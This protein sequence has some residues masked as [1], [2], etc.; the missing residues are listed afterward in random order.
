[1]RSFISNATSKV[2]L[3]QSLSMIYFPRS[4]SNKKEQI[5]S[6]NEYLTTSS[7]MK[8]DVLPAS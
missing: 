5:I 3:L 2:I 4:I 1:M 7:Y 8:Y 6:Y